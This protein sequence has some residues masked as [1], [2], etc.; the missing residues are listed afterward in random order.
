MR[1]LIFVFLIFFG[2]QIACSA[3]NEN[4]SAYQYN[5]GKCR[6]KLLEDGIVYFETRVVKGQ[7]TLLMI[8]GS[9]TRELYACIRS[10]IECMSPIELGQKKYSYIF[11][12]TNF[13]NK[14][15]DIKAFKLTNDIS[16]SVTVMQSFY[17]NTVN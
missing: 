8:K 4:D 14:P 7:N 12:N 5:F 2:F 9:H 10:T 15:P 13:A 3:Q 16:D 1:L 11:T 6:A 17:G